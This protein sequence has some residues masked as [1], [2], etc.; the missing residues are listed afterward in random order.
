V[1]TPALQDA[2]D[3][4]LY[5]GGRSSLPQPADGGRHP[6]RVRVGLRFGSDAYL[7]GSVAHHHRARR[8]SA[9]GRQL[10]AGYRANWAENDRHARNVRVASQ[11]RRG[12]FQGALRV[13][14]RSGTIAGMLADG[15]GCSAARPS[16]C[17]LVAMRRRCCSALALAHAAGMFMRV[18]GGIYTKAADVGADLV[19]KVE[20]DVPR[21]TP[22][23][24]GNS[25]P[26]GR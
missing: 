17:S 1:K 25:R 3:L 6:H 9:L 12:S 26:G 18:G 13:A 4:G 15:W 14:Y 16:L 24:S 7:P 5:S 19:G 8:G 23:C 22:Q 10:F 11:A 21:T 20:A 2:R